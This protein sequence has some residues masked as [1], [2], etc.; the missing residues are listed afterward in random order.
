MYLDAALLLSGS[1]SATNQLTGQAV[2]GAGTI[3]SANTIDVAP[4]SLGSNQPGDI[5][6]GEDLN[7]AFSVLSA[8]TGGTSVQFQVI[9]ADD[10]ALTTNVEVL[11]STDA[12]PIAKLPVGTVIKLAINP[13][14]G[15]AKRY[16]GTRY[17]NV[18]AIATC[19]IAAAVVK[20]VQG[21]GTS[22]KSGYT[23]A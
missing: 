3:L 4:L 17:I 19:S 20:D 12:V 8:P 10:A 21:K 22:F 9:H 18:G 2:N 6:A 11:S 7:V 14:P 23:I 16:V 1:V 15:A 13:A 5:G